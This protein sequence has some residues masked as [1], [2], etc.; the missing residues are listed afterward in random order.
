LLARLFVPNAVKSGKPISS[1][2][3]RLRGGEIVEMDDLARMILRQ[4]KEYV[5][6]V[7]ENGIIDAEFV[8]FLEEKAKELKRW[9]LT[10]L[11]EE[12]KL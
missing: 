5:D 9:Y 11:D 2:L 6:N 7:L 1:N 4:L 3:E 8:G 12:E 10:K